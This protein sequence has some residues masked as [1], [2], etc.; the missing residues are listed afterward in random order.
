MNT[1]FIVVMGGIA[2]LL[3]TLSAISSIAQSNATRSG[4]ARWIALVAL[5]PVVGWGAWWHKGPKRP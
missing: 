2:L 1:N 5:V 4:K 3:I